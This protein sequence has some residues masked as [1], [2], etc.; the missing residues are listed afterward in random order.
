[1]G[2]RE[3]PELQTFF[4][5]CN[6][7]QGQSLETIPASPNR[8]LTFGD[9]SGER[10]KSLGVHKLEE[11]TWSKHMKS[12]LM[13]PMYR[14]HMCPWSIKEQFSLFQS[15]KKKN[16]AAIQGQTSVQVEKNTWKS[17]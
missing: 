1:M 11:T 6:C 13:A 3:L 15:K 16:P 9:G 4:L 14:I 5:F 2:A 17:L 7:I 10:I 12:K 8:N